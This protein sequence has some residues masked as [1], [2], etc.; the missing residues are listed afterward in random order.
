MRAGGSMI[1]VHGV[2]K[3]FGP[4]R[5]LDVVSVSVAPGRTTALLGPS[6]G[7]KSTLLRV[8]NGLVR[9]DAGDV[10]FDGALLTPAS[11]R[12]VRHQIGYVVQDGG[13]F[14]HLTAAGN[15]T[16]LARHLGWDRNRV[17]TRLT[18]LGKLARLPAE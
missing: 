15:V 17:R 9:P 10:Y 14:P 4:V 5:V 2:S 6:G 18:A 13:L 12:S 7:G 16:L 1:D 11:A 8:M 3:S